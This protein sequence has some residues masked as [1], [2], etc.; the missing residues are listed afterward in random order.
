MWIIESECW[1]LRKIKEKNSFQL[2]LSCL[3]LLSLPLQIQSTWIKGARKEKHSANRIT[4]NIRILF[5][6]S[7]LDPLVSCGQRQWRGDCVGDIYIR[8]W[9]NQGHFPSTTSPKSNIIDSVLIIASLFHEPRLSLG[10]IYFSN[11]QC[12]W[13]I[14]SCKAH[15]CK[16]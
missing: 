13:T 5:L 12:P 7:S 2:N 3:P 10:K 1:K 6:Y 4:R 15:Q 8:T 11:I 9:Y 14:I 16:S